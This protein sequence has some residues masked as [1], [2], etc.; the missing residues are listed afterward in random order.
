MLPA[1]AKML[2]LSGNAPAVA[3]AGE[4][5]E[6]LRGENADLQAD[7]ERLL[8]Y[9]EGLEASGAGGAGNGGAAPSSP[10]LTSLG[11]P[12]SILHELSCEPSVTAAR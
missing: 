7:N 12:S 6:A 3:A 2:R 5:L 4:L 1:Q 10:L 11:W 8:A 9:A